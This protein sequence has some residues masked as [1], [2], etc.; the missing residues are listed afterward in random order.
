MDHFNQVSAQGTVQKGLALLECAVHFG[1]LLKAMREAR[2]LT[3]VRLADAAHVSENTIKA[4][5]GSPECKLRRS[6]SIAVLE[7][8][9]R[10]QP[11]SPEEQDAFLDAADL[12]K[13]YETTK[14]FWDEARRQATEDKRQEE[15]AK[16][17]AAPSTEANTSR[18]FGLLHSLLA[19]HDS[20]TVVSMLESVAALAAATPAA[21]PSPAPSSPAR[22]RATV[23]TPAAEAPGRAAGST[24]RKKAK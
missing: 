9:E 5:E 14:P 20:R 19:K 6:N 1:D 2:R 7:A 11:L 12:R 24:A 10:V 18:A 3:Q 13:I 23:V 21:P 17:A 22:P 4:A 8:L 15:A 16:P